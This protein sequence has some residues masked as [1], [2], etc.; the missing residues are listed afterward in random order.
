MADLLAIGK[1]LKVHGLKG[2]IKVASYLESN[3]VINNLSEIFI[4]MEK[5]PEAF[6]IE[7]V[8][9]NNKGLFIT[10]QRIQSADAAAKLVGREVLMPSDQLD[11]LPE[12]EYYWKDLVGLAVRTE[13]GQELGFIDAIFSAGSNDVYVC[14]SSKKEILLPA[15]RDVIKEIDLSK[16]I[17]IVNLLEGL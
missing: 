14:R 17:M 5:G 9:F 15:I 8:S 13:D 1:V 4:V 11:D 10:L 3:S 12:G 2:T 7:H 16:K 6:S